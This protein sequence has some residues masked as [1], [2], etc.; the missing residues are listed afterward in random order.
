MKVT[1]LRSATQND[2]GLQYNIRK[3]IIPGQKND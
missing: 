3:N 1:K 2:K